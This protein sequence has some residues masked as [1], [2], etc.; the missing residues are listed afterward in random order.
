[1]AAISNKDIQV[2]L[3]I[4]V[5][6]AEAATSIKDVRKAIK[7][8]QSAALEFKDT[9]DE[10]F[11]RATAAAGSLSD[12]LRDVKE[13]IKAVSGSELENIGTSFGQIKNNITGL[14]FGQ[15]AKGISN[16]SASIK[17]ANPG[18]LA[19]QFKGLGT[20]LLNL[21]KVLMTNPLFLI[22][23]VIGGVI[24]ALYELK[25]AGGVVTKI[26]GAIG[27]A[28]NVVIEFMKKLTDAI[29]L[30][31][32]EAQ[33][34][35]ENQIKLLEQQGKAWS[36]YFKVKYSELQK[37][38]KSTESL[39]FENAEQQIEQANNVLQAQIKLI[40]ESGK[41][42]DESLLNRIKNGEDLTG[43]L[44]GNEQK[45][46]D[47]L[48]KLGEEYTKSS[49]DA[50][51]KDAEYKEFLNKKAGESAKNKFQQEKD[52]AI[53]E[54]NLLTNSAERAKKIAEA[55]ATYEKQTT[56]LKNIELKERSN[57]EDDAY[58]QRKRKLQK[59]IDDQTKIINDGREKL[60]EPLSTWEKDNQFS[61][62]S[63]E[64]VL[65]LRNAKIEKEIE[66]SEQRRS[67]IKQEIDKLNNDNAKT[68]SDESKRIAQ[69]AA[70]DQLQ[71]QK[72]LKIKL[73]TIDLENL[74]QRRAN[75]KKINDDIN[76]DTQ[77]SAEEKY[78]INKE[79]LEMESK[80]ID[81][82]FKLQLSLLS[83]TDSSKIKEL[84]RSHDEELKA[85]QLAQN[86]LYKDEIARLKQF[87]DDRIN[88]KNDQLIKELE[89]QRT[90][91]K[92]ITDLDT[93]TKNTLR[94]QEEKDLEI[95]KQKY[96]K[97][98]IAAGVNVKL[99]TAL[100]DEYNKDVTQIK[101][102]ADEGWYKLDADYYNSYKELLLK[103]KQ[104]TLNAEITNYENRS[105]WI[106][107]GADLYEENLKNQL[108]TNEL[109]K[110]IEL[111]AVKGNAEQEF[112][113]KQKYAAMDQSLQNDTN[114]KIIGM[115]KNRA[116]V[117]MG[118]ATQI[119]DIISVQSQNEIADSERRI[120]QADIEKTNESNSV[121]E[122]LD[123]QKAKFDAST[124]TDAA[125]QAFDI[126]IEK[127]KY[128]AQIKINKANYD[129]KVAEYKNQE[130]LKEDEF[131]RNKSFQMANAILATA[132]AV[133]TPLAMTPPNIPLSII[134]GITGALTMAKIA[135]TT[136]QPGAAPQPDYIA[137]PT[138]QF[139]ST[140][141]VSANTTTGLMTNSIGLKQQAFDYQKVY[142]LESDI[143]SV[144]NRI[145]V[146][147][148]RSKLH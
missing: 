91:L 37:D 135:S 110:N 55:N 11:N 88:V 56:D 102:K 122:S 141:G 146:I 127:Q 9:N 13:N 18:K 138:T 6:N 140:S 101:E 109:N 137:P 80:D 40:K 12:K 119:S 28:V 53:A 104:E 62:K 121:N 59:D 35:A 43:K 108:K 36:N 8:L 142:V 41:I 1:M 61:L 68:V 90:N 34:Q 107:K 113:I 25:D 63:E 87:G 118:F 148:D 134:G 48:G 75:N 117:I 54:A 31:N 22:A 69:K 27:D 97:D 86:K 82:N 15:A 105:E 17:G 128:D 16:L 126:K 30:T 93:N 136:Y 57:S 47:K 20:E 42:T 2:K 85:N 84:K 98:Y 133:L 144:T 77:V 143:S 114:S 129:L 106:T 73:I 24:A 78:L 65:K 44:T 19:E 64:D 111:A 45:M 26:F 95:R 76:A 147:E 32:F 21:G 103:N 51:T 139:Q 89:I 72:D 46:F 60:K 70:D 94:A 130:K 71:I 132:M 145:N 92:S 52:L 33:R 124:A 4:L 38:L 74:T 14:D 10:A 120:Q 125:K 123:L 83:L 5:Q 29:G 39:E 81:K 50:A 116:D 49:I 100:E 58:H 3:D 112:A 23:A 96:D 7:D 131:N 66:E 115:W 99:K 79:Y 67:N